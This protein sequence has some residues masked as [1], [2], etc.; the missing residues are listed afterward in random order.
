[1]GYPMNPA[2]KNGAAG[3]PL[4]KSLYHYDCALRAAPFSSDWVKT[5]TPLE[6]GVFV[7]GVLT[8]A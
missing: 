7:K 2:L 6:S 1:M 5:K 4:C 8:T 3:S